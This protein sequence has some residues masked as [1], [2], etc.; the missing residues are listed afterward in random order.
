MGIAKK[1]AAVKTLVETVSGMLPK[2]KRHRLLHL[3]NGDNQYV[4][5][6]SSRAIA[7]R[8]T[9]CEEMYEIAKLNGVEIVCSDLP[10]LYKHEASPAESFLRK[11]IFA[12]QEHE[13]SKMLKLMGS[14]VQHRTNMGSRV[15]HKLHMGSE[16]ATQNSP[17]VGPWGPGCSHEISQEFER[18][19]LVQRLQAGLAA[20]KAKSKAI[21]QSGEKKC[22]GTKSLLDKQSLTAKQLRELKKYAKEYINQS[23]GLRTLASKFSNVLELEENIHHETARRMVEELHLKYGFKA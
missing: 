20:A 1:G 15:Q 21:T 19:T 22:Q 14:G 4:V 13:S 9:T 5:V 23:I 18:D 6:E 10:F 7:R 17:G 8:A 2:E 11:V 12:T 16:G 3:L